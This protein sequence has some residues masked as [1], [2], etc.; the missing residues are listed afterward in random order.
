MTLLLKQKET[1]P[2]TEAQVSLEA[3]AFARDPA[4]V[5]E[6]RRSA[7]ERFE[8]IGFPTERRGN[9]EWKYTD[10]RPMVRTA[11][12]T[13]LDV[14]PAGAGFNLGDI[15][16]FTFGEIG[17]HRLVFVD[18]A[19]R[20]DLSSVDSVP[21]GVT[22]A[23][24]GEAMKTRP[25]EVKPHLGR[26]VG[27]EAEGFAALNTAFL[28]DGAFINVPNGAVVLEPIHLVFLSTK[29][30]RDAAAFPRVLIVTGRDTKVTVIETYGGLAEGRAFANGVSEVV[31]GEGSVVNRYF[32]QSHSEE[33][34]TVTTAN[35]EVQANGN[36]SSVYLD[37]GGATTRNNLTVK[38][39]GEGGFARL[40]GAYVIT[41]SQHV[42]NQVIIDHLVGHTG[43]RELYKGVLDGRARS[44]F[45][46]SI[47]VRAGAVK[48]DALQQ[49]KN[50]LLSD[51]AEADTKPAFWIYCDDVRCGHGAACGA[52]DEDALFYL[53]SR[54]LDEAS[55]RLIL[56]RGF[57]SEIVDTVDHPVLRQHID[58]LVTEKFRNL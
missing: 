42:D 4:W 1:R 36:F 30:S 16:Q 49:D 40:N 12:R 11:F 52:I 21:G 17:W 6:I 48:V 34:F 46:G 22:V 8:L 7:T 39:I 58:A 10:V 50:L 27:D 43:A 13:S 53:R 33:T 44:V 14:T 15:E 2:Y 32:I 19:Y 3:G 20:S 26:L 56:I 29:A 24:L 37:L 38:M 35:V 25:D 23:S 47:I 51:Q 28:H 54:G 5:R 9:E 57:I 31:V 41:R 45:H 55:A 18:G